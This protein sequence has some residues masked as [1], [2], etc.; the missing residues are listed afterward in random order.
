MAKLYKTKRLTV[1]LDDYVIEI[2]KQKAQIMFKGSLDYYI[3]WLICSNNKQEIKKKVKSQEKEI[4]KKKPLA[5]PD[6]DKIAIYNN[7]CNFCNEPIFP[8]D[9][10]CK[11]EGYENYIHKKCSKTDKELLI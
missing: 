10:I 2:A 3:N 11:A 8:G 5:L 7:I 1:N 9:E 4:E 6:T